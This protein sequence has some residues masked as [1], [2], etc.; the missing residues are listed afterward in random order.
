MRRGFTIVELMIVIVVIAILAAITIVAYTN[1]Q[2]RARY[3]AAQSNLRSLGTAFD[4]Y[5]AENGIYPSDR[6]SIGIA[7][8]NTGALELGV[9][10]TRSGQDG[11]PNYMYCLR[12]DGSDLWVIAGDPVRAFEGDDMLYWQGNGTNFSEA[13]YTESV[14]GSYH[15]SACQAAAGST[16]D[17]SVWST[18]AT[19]LTGL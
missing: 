11:G 15:G 18:S 14:P 12:D 10:N 9:T 6:A 3:S 5:R 19:L 4:L 17:D 8:Q 7:L 1:V 2:E 16:Y 13:T